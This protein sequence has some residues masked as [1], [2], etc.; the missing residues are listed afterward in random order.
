MS[1][2]EAFPPRLHVKRDARR[3]AILDVAAECFM[4][5]GYAAA[6]MNLIAARVGGSKGTLYNHFR[7]KEELFAAVVQR[8]CLELR[9]QIVDAP[10]G[11]TTRARLTWMA[12]H[13]VAFLVRPQC[14]A[15]QRVIVGEG[16]RFPELGRLFYDA[17]PALVLEQV[18][19]EIGRMMQAGE[20]RQDKPER[21]AEHLK[22]LAVAGLHPQRL[23]G[24]VEDPTPET[25]DRQAQIA[26]DVFL[27]AYGAASA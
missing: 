15:L 6:S 16:G 8:A 14:L 26:V 1:L 4:Q 24:V 18:A 10:N 7:S 22:V 5:T 2:V 3:D 19:Q 12:R 20:L 23:W 11:L 25:L 21:A 9:D 17:G 13:L 27:R